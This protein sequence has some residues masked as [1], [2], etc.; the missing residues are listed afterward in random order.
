MKMNI[1]VMGLGFVGLT[2]A[3]GFAD[4]GLTVYG[5]DIDSD[6]LDTIRQGRIPFFEKGL[7]DA[8]TRTYEN[9][10]FVLE[11]MKKITGKGEIDAVFFCVG[12]PCDDTG[13]ADLTYLKA[14][15]KAVSAYIQEDTLLIIK[16]TIPPGTIDEYVKPYLDSLE[17]KNH[18]A[19]NPE[20]L[21]EGYCWSDFMNPN[22]I[23][24]GIGEDS[25]RDKDV[26]NNI[27]EGFSVPIHF[28]STSTAEFIKYL[29]NS[30]LANLISFSNEMALVAESVGDI[31]VKKAFEILHEDERLKGSGIAHYI[32]PGCGYGGYCLPKDTKALEQNAL[33]HGVNPSIL[34]STITLNDKM[35]EIMANKI[36]NKVREKNCTIGILGLSFKPDSDDV[37]E[38]SAAKIIQS[39]IQKGYTEIVAYDPVANDN[40]EKK[41]EFGIRY[42]KSAKEVCQKSDVVA[43]V[44][45]WKE[46]SHI[47]NQYPGLE[48]VDCRYFYD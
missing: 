5:Y 10:F 7:K 37:R 34:H 47:N 29:S 13:K 38:S 39:L 48:I 30:L 41:Y 11:D 19:S 12:T 15:I 2:T 28:V 9:T 18:I 23:V 42:E 46:F 45:T 40:F 27:Y 6:K 4:K 14:A 26:F 36:I 1:V 21:R 25:Q 44:T 43:V 32:Y 35:P 24:C 16:S 3:L 8:L 17:I 31:S 22:R 33:L 20:F